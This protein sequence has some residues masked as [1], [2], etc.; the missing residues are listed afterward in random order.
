MHVKNKALALVSLIILCLS[1]F[2]LFQG[3]Y[4]HDREVESMIAKEEEVIDGAIADIERYSF[5]SYRVKIKQI[6][7]NNH[8][9]RAAF[10]RRDRDLLV[11]HAGP[12]YE[13]LQE[14]NAHFHAWDFNEPD[15]RV[16]LRVQR[17]ELHGDNI[18]ETRAIIQ[19]VHESREPQD[20]YDIGKHGPIYW[21]AHPVFHGGGYA[22][23]TEF[24]IPALQLVEAL[25]K[26]FHAEVAILV[27]TSLWHQASLVKQGYRSF[28]EHILMS[29]KDSAYSLI[30]EDF[31]FSPPGDQEIIL[32]DRDFILHSCSVLRDFRGDPV[33][34]ILVL[35]DVSEKTAERKR[36]IAVALGVTGLL[37]SASFAVLFFS[38]G[39]L[40]GN[41][42][43]YA[44]EN[45]KARE[46][47]EDA[48][49]RLEHRVRQR[50]AD[51]QSIN[52]ALEMEISARA[53]VEEALRESH[54]RL[55]LVLDGLD[56]NVYVADMETY[57]I[58]FINKA[59]RENFGDIVG[60]KCWETIQS[61]QVGPCAF[62]TNRQLLDGEGKPSGTSIWE[63]KNEDQGKWYIIQDRAIRWVDGR[64]VRLAIA[65]DIT[66]R[67]LTEEKVR[68]SLQE[69]E[70]LLKEIHH[71]VKNNMQIISSL[72]NLEA[73][74]AGT[75][76]DRDIFRDSQSRIRAM[77]LV[78]EKL[79]QSHDLANINFREYIEDL[80]R[81]LYA[82][83]NADRGKVRTV[84]MAEGVTMGIDTAILCGL[85]VNE[86]VTNSLRHA[87]PEGK[88]G[89]I[90][91]SLEQ[92]G[93]GE[94][95]REAYR[96][97]VQ[98]DGVG[99]PAVISL[100]DAGTLGLQLVT[101]LAE[102]QLQGK[103]SLE[104][105]GGARFTIQFQELAYRGRT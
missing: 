99:V 16:F 61:G 64:T 77:A 50:T 103:V 33:G 73:A 28:G 62:C 75:E 70:V 4:R 72:L 89:E 42:E 63:F 8:D 79:Y 49:G 37:F 45:R 44:E 22:G 26:K 51:L 19:R 23:A 105:N 102:H 32:G 38:F 20:G 80:I 17:P 86:L 40:I 54:E 55:L 81:T 78:H 100:R 9:L 15:G 43:E 10:A 96:L 3:I 68:A 91:I 46:E 1:G 71:R 39:G 48:R 84:V 92:S 97:V 90:R 87:F 60:R 24:G 6:V 65:T 31:S 56:A 5:H 59:A 41:L 13:D 14:E 85:I 36:F 7:E 11:K 93:G 67:K 18:W 94:G 69:K 74:A 101:G 98:D 21:V 88:T 57:E 30:P 34:N 53:K 104:R 66:G 29:D 27:K 2:F 58:L 47:V 76:G 83:Y 35:Q 12:I 95:K 82:L 52:Q 25:K